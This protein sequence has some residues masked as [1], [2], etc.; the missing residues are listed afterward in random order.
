MLVISVISVLAEF[1]KQESS[2]NSHGPCGAFARAGAVTMSLDW[3][4]AGGAP[5]DVVPRIRKSA[6]RE[7][8][9]R[10]LTK[11]ERRFRAELPALRQAHR[12]EAPR[13]G[14]PMGA[15]WPPAE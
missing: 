15:K 5:T 10:V 12:R 8:G 7:P 2:A 6:V 4:G 14:A 13:Q 9:K 11:P 3:P 1:W